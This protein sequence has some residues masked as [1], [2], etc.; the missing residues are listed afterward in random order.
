MLNFASV[1]FSAETLSSFPLW[2]TQSPTWKETTDSNS[3][4]WGLKQTQNLWASK[5]KRG[6]AE[7][8]WP[9][10]KKLSAFSHMSNNAKTLEMKLSPPRSLPVMSVLLCNCLHLPLS[11]KAVAGRKKASWVPACP[12]ILW[13]R[14][15]GAVQNSSQAALCCSTTSP[16]TPNEVVSSRSQLVF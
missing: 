4:D 16:L 12:W 9:P 2:L 10:L 14:I 8:I 5:L 6:N 1:T 3:F 13:H 7:A 11:K 15:R